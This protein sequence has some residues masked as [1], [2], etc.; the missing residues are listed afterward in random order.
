MPK[1]NLFIVLVMLAGSVVAWLARDHAGHGRRF[2]EAL[3]GIERGHLEPVD[4]RGLFDTAMAAVFATLDEHSAW[5]GTDGREPRGAVAEREF[6]GVGIELAAAD[7]LRGIAVVGPVLA[8][9]A[10]HAGIAAGDRILAIDGIPAGQFTLEEACRRLRGVPGTTVSLT[11]ASAAGGTDAA[12]AT[13]REVPLRRERVEM[14]TVLGDRRRPDGSWEWMV[15]G[16]PGVALLRITS[17]GD[18]TAEAVRSAVDAIAVRMAADASAAGDAAA[19]AGLLIVDLRGNAG[20]QAAAAVEVC[21]LFLDDGV[22]VSTRRRSPAGGNAAVSATSDTRRATRGAAVPDVPMAVL[23]DGL[24]AHVAEVVAACLQDHRRAVVVGSRT[25]GHGTVQSIVP[26]ADGSGSFRLTTAEYLRPGGGAIHRWDTPGGDDSAW[27][28]SPD[29][30]AAIT[31]TGRQLEAW[32]DWRR[33]RDLVPAKHDGAVAV[34][35]PSLAVLPR[36]VDAVL[37]RAIDVLRGL[38]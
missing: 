12:A 16:E 17:F 37:T 20:G 22:I 24:T 5:L 10:W 19:A 6:G 23:V 33:Q 8:S 2:A 13:T 21:D 3:A 9:P 4:P 38:P 27:G 11:V 25:F 18:R 30:G 15:E 14:E 36:R 1:R 35:P 26:L 34:D 29:A 32:R 28:V 31:P 7:P